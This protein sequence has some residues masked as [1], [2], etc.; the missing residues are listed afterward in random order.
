MPIKSNICS[1]INY[2]VKMVKLNQIFKM[3]PSRKFHFFLP[4]AVGNLYLI[5]KHTTHSLFWMSVTLC[6]FFCAVLCVRYCTG[7]FVMMPLNLTCLH[8]LNI[9]S[10]N[11]SSIYIETMTHFKTSKIT[12]LCIEIKTNFKC[13]LYVNPQYMNQNFD[14]NINW[15]DVKRK[16]GLNNV[17]MSSLRAL[18]Q[19]DPYKKKQKKTERHKNT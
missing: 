3:P 5:P 14:N 10:L 16:N 12:S 1:V 2:R 19:N 17:D 8:Y 13:N 4:P 15:R 7:H 9:F 6:C 11:I 18:W